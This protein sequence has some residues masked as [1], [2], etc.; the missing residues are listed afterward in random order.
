MCMVP[1]QSVKS[2]ILHFLTFSAYMRCFLDNMYN[3]EVCFAVITGNWQET[4]KTSSDFWVYYWSDFFY[5]IYISNLYHAGLYRSNTFDLWFAIEQ[6]S[7]R[8]KFR[9]HIFAIR[10]V[11]LAVLWSV[12]WP[13]S[14]QKSHIQEAGNPRTLF[15]LPGS[16]S[17]RFLLNSLTV[18]SVIGIQR[19][20]DAA[21]NELFISCRNK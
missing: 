8:Q 7:R 10:S 16:R 6:S 17:H 11:R 9:F 3:W 13:T 18:L 12:S 2:H 21:A 4:V 15:Q 5:K 14:S 20:R 19:A 1:L